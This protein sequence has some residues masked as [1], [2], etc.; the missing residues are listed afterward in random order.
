MPP[1]Q[2]KYGTLVTQIEEFED[3]FG[4]MP[5]PPRVNWH[6]HD[7]LFIVFSGIN[8]MVSTRLCG[9]EWTTA[10]VWRRDW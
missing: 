3:L 7:S 1:G 4:P 9:A 6:A 2:A 5:G 10:A 8:D